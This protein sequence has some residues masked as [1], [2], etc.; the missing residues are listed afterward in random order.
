MMIVHQCVGMYR[1]HIPD[2]I[3]FQQNIKVTVQQI[4]MSHNGLFERQDDVSSV[5]YW[6]QEDKEMSKYCPLPSKEERWPR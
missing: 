4:G 1:F 2:P 3:Y 5:A 6:Y